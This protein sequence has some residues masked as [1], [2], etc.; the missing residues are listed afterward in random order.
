[1]KRTYYIAY[2][3]NL[4]VNQMLRRC[5]DAVKIGAAVIE[6]YKLAFRR[7]VLNIEAAPGKRVPVGV[8]AISDAD[9][10]AL[11]RYEGYPR[12]YEKMFFRLTVNGKTIQAM[13]YV[14]TPGHLTA[15]P[16]RGYYGIVAEGYADFG[17]D[18]APLLT[19]ASEAC[20]E[21]AE[22]DDAVS[23]VIFAK[24]AVDAYAREQRRRNASRADGWQYCPRCGGHVL[25][26]RLSSNALSRYAD[27][28]ICGACGLDEA[29]RAFRGYPLSLKDW[30]IAQ[31]H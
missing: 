9:E 5:P 13:A 25:K 27:V 30:D 8:W 28:Y 3:S 29:V 17:F 2:G 18:E 24:K 15:A 26:S 31:K 21:K 1:M 11:D 20:E 19:A 7:G 16:S 23:A 4:N 14:M 10:A 12:L 22:F 6:D